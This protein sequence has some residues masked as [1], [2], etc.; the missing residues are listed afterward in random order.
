MKLLYIINDLEYF[1][2]HRLD[3][4]VAAKECGFSVYVFY[5]M[6]RRG[7]ISK[8][9]KLDIATKQYYLN[10]KNVN[11]FSEIFTFV[12]LLIFIIKLRPKLI[13]AISV[14][15][16][17]YGGIISRLLRINTVFAISGLGNIGFLTKKNSMLKRILLRPV[18][19]LA[20]NG[21]RSKI[22][23]QNQSDK[24]FLIS[25]LNL[26]P[27]NIVRTN[28]SGVNLQ[29]I[30][31]ADHFNEVPVITLAARL[32]REKGISEFV[33]AA[34]TFKKLNIDANFWIIGERDEGSPHSI[35][36]VE[37]K[38]WS[39]EANITFWGYR[40]D[41]IH[42]YQKSDIV[43]LPSYYAEGM[44]KSL[45]EAAAC[46]RAIVT[47]DIPGCADTVIPDKTGILVSPKNNDELVAALQYLAFNPTKCREFGKL[48]RLFAEERFNIDDVISLHLTIYHDVVL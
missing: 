27:E 47:T 29:S 15:S 5:G 43:C 30:V 46:G 39:K 6:R 35:T 36:T 3:I 18:F 40:A 16:Y 8:L 26:L 23:V 38:E 34:K 28:G 7:D 41:V 45:L 48:S 25:W 14:K 13:H 2:S 17:L 10:R 20:L 31:V 11:I 33:Q 32:I 12:S 37:L 42:L 4:A 24:N 1:I 21:K 44:P 19:K 22:I 9:H